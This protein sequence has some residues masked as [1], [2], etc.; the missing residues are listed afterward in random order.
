MFD[1]RNGKTLM[2]CFIPDGLSHAATSFVESLKTNSITEKVRRDRWVV[3]KRRNVYGERAAD[4]INFYFRAAGLPIRHLSD[5]GF[6]SRFVFC[7]PTTMPP[8]S[9]N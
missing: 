5:V 7:A 3:I 4:L 8:S 2:D 9:A 1:F 6:R